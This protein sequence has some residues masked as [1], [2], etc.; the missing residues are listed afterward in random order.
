MIY[1]RNE[2]Q[3]QPWFD[4]LSASLAE[5]TVFP[6]FHT[7]AALNCASGLKLLGIGNSDSQ[8]L[9]CMGWQEAQGKRVLLANLSAQA[10][11]I[12]LKGLGKKSCIGMLDEQSFVQACTN[13]LTF[14]HTSQWLDSKKGLTLGAYAVACVFDPQA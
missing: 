12:N 10:V 11:Q 7:L 8:R 9:A 14:R 2:D 13:P 6:V 5:H 1:S 4:G 3:P